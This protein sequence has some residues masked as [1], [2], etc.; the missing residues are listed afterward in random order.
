[1]PNVHV[2][3]T[4]VTD[5]LLDVLLVTVIDTDI[6]DPEYDIPTAPY[7]NCPAPEPLDIG[8]AK[9]LRL[10][11]KA[12]APEPSWIDQFHAIVAP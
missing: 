4:S 2:K 8:A 1:M 3:P 7:T 11:L 9:L 6:D 5:I 12:F 10:K